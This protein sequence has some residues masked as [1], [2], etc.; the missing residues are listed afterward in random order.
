MEDRITALFQEWAGQGGAVLVERSTSVT[1][2][3]PETLIAESTG[4]C[5][6]S[7]RLTWVLLDWLI[8]HIDRIEPTRLI[9]ATRDRG[10]LG[11]LGVVC[12]AARARIA[13]TRL[14]EIIRNCVS[15]PA[16][17]VFFH[18]VA[19]SPFASRLARENTL[20]LFRRWNYYCDELHYLSAS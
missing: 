13:D 19:R 11:V 4:Y 3:S 16:P 18:R 5:R 6:D 2:R 9:E 8:R 17:E 1:A 15:P 10:D 20:D 12:D 7:S 14:D